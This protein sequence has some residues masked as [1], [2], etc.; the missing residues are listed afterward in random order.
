MKSFFSILTL[1]LVVY[2]FIGCKRQNNFST[3]VQ[4]N[5]STPDLTFFDLKGHVHTVN[6]ESDS[7]RLEFF[8]DGILKSI[9]GDR[10]Y[11]RKGHFSGFRR[12]K[13]QELNDYFVAYYD[14]TSHTDYQ[15]S[16]GKVVLSTSSGEG[17]CTKTEYVYDENGDLKFEKIERGEPKSS[18]K[19]E[20]TYTITKRD[21]NGNWTERE[22]H[23]EQLTPFYHDGFLIRK[24]YSSESIEERTITYY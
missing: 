4:D 7:K 24:P 10:P 1:V 23:E 3:P 12:G 17:S 6:S 8:P 20:K 11:S 19:W 14:I 21:W 18:C 16:N 15:W 5:F 22:V 2:C 13:S 9:N